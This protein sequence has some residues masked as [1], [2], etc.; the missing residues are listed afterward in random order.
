MPSGSL[1]ATVD[2]S[3]FPMGTRKMRWRRKVMWLAGMSWKSYVTKNIF[4]TVLLGLNKVWGQRG[5]E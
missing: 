4:T 3:S 2:P 5:R 1:G